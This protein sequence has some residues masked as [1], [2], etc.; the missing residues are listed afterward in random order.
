ML[1]THSNEADYFASQLLVA[2]ATNERSILQQREYSRRRQ[3][4]DHD[5]RTQLTQLKDRQLTHTQP[6]NRQQEHD[7]R[8]LEQEETLRRE[9]D[10]FQAAASDLRAFF[11]QPPRSAGKPPVEAPA[12]EDPLSQ[13]TETEKQIK[14]RAR[15]LIRSKGTGSAGILQQAGSSAIERNQALALI[16]GTISRARQL[17]EYKAACRVR[18]LRGADVEVRVRHVGDDAEPEQ[19]AARVGGTRGKG[20]TR[21][22]EPLTVRA[23]Q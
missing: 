4:M 22:R 6:R 12:R 18:A 13:Y 11:Q 15:K 21:H 19:A 20:E 3:Q 23:A 16:A 2:R 14:E 1:R 7:R 8:T 9:K 17:P 10:Q 5:I